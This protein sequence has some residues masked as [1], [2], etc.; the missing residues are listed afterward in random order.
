[1]KRASGIFLMGFLL[2]GA[3]MLAAQEESEEN[4]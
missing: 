4:P 3:G 1:M 2:A